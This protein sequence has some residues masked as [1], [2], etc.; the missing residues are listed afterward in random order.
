M[1]DYEFKETRF[2]HLVFSISP[3]KFSIT[4]GR[5]GSELSNSDLVL[6]RGKIRPNVG[7]AH[8]VSHYL[9]GSKTPFFNDYSQNRPSSSKLA[10]AMFFYQMR[11]P[12]I[13]TYSSLNPDFLKSVI[14]RRLNFPVILKDCFGSH[15]HN[16]Y[17]VSTNE[18]LDRILL[19]NPKIQ[20]AAQAYHPNDCDFRIL[21]MGEQE[22]LVIKRTATQGSHLNNTSQG[23]SAELSSEVPQKYID[24]AKKIASKLKMTLAGVDLILDSKTGEMLFLEINSQPQILSG[25]FTQEKEDRLSKLIGGLLN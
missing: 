2:D 15:G 22:P 3:E 24:D 14:N 23:G 25:A 11:L 7:L 10:Q 17:L 21:I 6:I 20:F 8:I 16:N 18:E 4:D 12:F 5:D 9:A 19:E 13:E 1:P